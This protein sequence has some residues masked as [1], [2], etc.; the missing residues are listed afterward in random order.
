MN[1]HTSTSSAASE[2]LPLLPN[3]PAS[4]RSPSPKSSPTPAEFSSAAACRTSAT[5]D[6]Q[7]TFP[8]FEAPQFCPP[9]THANRHHLPGSAEA[10]KIT[11]GS[12]RQLATLSRLSG[13]L[14]SLVRMC[15]GTSRWGST[16]CFLTWKASVTPRNRLLFQLA[17]SEHASAATES[18]LWV[19]TPNATAFK[20]GRL[21][22]RKGVRRPQ[23]N[24]YQ[25]QCSLMFGLRYPLPELGEQIMGYP[26]G[27][28]LPATARSAMRSSRKSR[29]S[30]SVGSPSSKEMREAA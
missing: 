10:R 14:G 17:P 6:S 9:A 26:L 30:S 28:T 3:V 8:G 23:T 21:K 27:W 7:E 15:L 16:E 22:P 18:G 11:A 12:G 29:S 20:G 2:D 5:S 1:L 13:P 19:V 4:A 24:N 25:D